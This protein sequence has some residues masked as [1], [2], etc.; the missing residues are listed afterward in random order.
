[1]PFAYKDSRIVTFIFYN[2]NII[3]THTSLSLSWSWLHFISF[4]NFS[5]PRANTNNRWIRKLIYAF[6]DSLFQHACRFDAHFNR[7]LIFLSTPLLVICLRNGENLFVFIVG[8]G[9][10]VTTNVSATDLISSFTNSL[11]STCA[12]LRPFVIGLIAIQSW[13]AT[14]SI[15]SFLP[16]FVACFSST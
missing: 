5:L 7:L 1:M 13:L 16:I 9:A 15:I 11:Q 12:P 10:D 6:R 2:R 3:H 8:F 14:N 4:T